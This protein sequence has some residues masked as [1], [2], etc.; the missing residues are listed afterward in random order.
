VDEASPRD[1]RLSPKTYGVFYHAALAHGA[2]HVWVVHALNEEVQELVSQAL[3]GRK[4]PMAETSVYKAAEELQGLQK[5]M[6]IFKAAMKRTLESD[7][8]PEIRRAAARLLFTKKGEGVYQKADEELLAAR[9]L[10]DWEA[11]DDELREARKQQARTEAKTAFLKAAE[12]TLK[13]LK[14]FVEGIDEV[15]HA[16][17]ALEQKRTACHKAVELR[18]ELRREFGNPVT[19]DPTGAYYMEDEPPP[20]PSYVN[21]PS[22]DTPMGAMLIYAEEALGDGEIE[23]GKLKK[24]TVGDVITGA[25]KKA[26]VTIAEPAEA[27]DSDMDEDVAMQDMESDEAY[28][29]LHDKDEVVMKECRMRRWRPGMRCPPRSRRPGRR[30]GLPRRRQRSTGK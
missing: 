13:A 29:H 2:R 3:E 21:P 30:R 20:G 4:L 6:T 22:G 28:T 19:L 14:H 23:S 24:A 10:N 12:D 27:H 17:W 26:K 9:G 16:K 1:D 15:E 11:P 5:G 25:F 18:H 8:T 7:S